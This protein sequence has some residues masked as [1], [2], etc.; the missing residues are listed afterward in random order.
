[1]AREAL[2][3]WDGRIVVN[4]TAASGLIAPAITGEGERPSEPNGES[5]SEP[6]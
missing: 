1:L 4:D 3:R 2:Q 6:S 5:P